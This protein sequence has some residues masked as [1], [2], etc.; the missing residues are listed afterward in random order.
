MILR[1]RTPTR[2][3]PLTAALLALA[4]ITPAA[5]QSAPPAA[6]P[7]TLHVTVVSEHGEHVRHLRPEAFAVSAGGRDARIVSFEDGDVPAT[8]GIL[9][10]AS[11]SMRSRG[12]ADSRR[13]V[14]AAL[15]SLFRSA[16]STDEFFLVAFNERPQLILRDTSDTAALTAA[17]DRLAAAKTAGQTALYDAM[18]LAL[19]HASNGRHA[20]RVLV[21]FTDGQDNRSSYEF[22]DVRSALR[23]GDVIVYMVH[24]TY[25][26]N[27]DLDMSGRA[28][29]EELAGMSG[30]KAYFPGNEKELEDTMSR[31]AAELRSQYALGVVPAPASRKDNWHDIKV[32]L[33]ARGRDEKGK[34]VK[35]YARTR[36]G[37]YWPERGN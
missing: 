27:T 4:L 21:V 28:V 20:K 5:A 6:A 3:D 22:A 18:Y 8:V 16:E 14:T 32:K 13:R 12:A 9:F 33:S 36:K 31:I 35:L 19:N 15:R 34:A 17:F 30:G 1:R 24:F 26:Y 37:F 11:G 25:G 7:R 29:A 2:A 23:E 10:D